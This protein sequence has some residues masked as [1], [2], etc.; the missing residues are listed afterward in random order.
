MKKRADL[1]VTAQK[2]HR[3]EGTEGNERKVKPDKDLEINKVGFES[4][5]LVQTVWIVDRWMLR[6]R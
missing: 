1:P 2:L 4:V 3:N 6:K 5:S